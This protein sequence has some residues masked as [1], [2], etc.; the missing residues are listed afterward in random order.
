MARWVKQQT[1]GRPVMLPPDADED[2]S[3]HAEQQREAVEQPR[4]EK[5]DLE[6]P[7]CLPPEGKQQGDEEQQHQPLPSRHAD[8]VQERACRRQG[9]HQPDQWCLDAI[10]GHQLVQHEHGC[11]SKHHGGQFRA[12]PQVEKLKNGARSR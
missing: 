8:A 2:G 4:E 7:A 10:V 11:R 1:P 9:D 5:A 3:A 12:D 6:E